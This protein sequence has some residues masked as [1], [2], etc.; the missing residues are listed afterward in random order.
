LYTRTGAAFSQAAY[1]TAAHGDAQ[2]RLG[3]YVALADDY[4][5]VGAPNED[6]SSQRVGDGETD[7]RAA[8]SGAAYIFR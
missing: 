2:D 7:N 3:Y 8:E 4:A 6:S 5:V 1:L